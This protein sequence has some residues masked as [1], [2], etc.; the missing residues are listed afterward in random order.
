[1]ITFTQCAALDWAPYKINVNAVLPGL[2]ETDMVREVLE[3]WA[4]EGGS[5]VKEVVDQVV[6]QIPWGRIETPQDI[7][8]AVVFL[9]SDDA[10]YI[11]GESLNVSGGLEMH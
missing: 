11:T 7:G 6:A 5:S 10:E 8:K 9:A 3:V 2:A 1:M 4:G